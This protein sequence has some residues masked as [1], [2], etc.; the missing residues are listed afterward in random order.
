MP[1]CAVQRLDLALERV[2]LL[3]Q[4]RLIGAFHGCGCLTSQKLVLPVVQRWTA[5]AELVGYSLR[6]FFA[7]AKRHDSRLHQL[8]GIPSSTQT[9]ND[10]PSG[11]WKGLA[12]PSRQRSPAGVTQCPHGGCD[13]AVVSKVVRDGCLLLRV[14]I[15]GNPHGITH[16]QVEPLLVFTVPA[17]K[18]ILGRIPQLTNGRPDAVAKLDVQLDRSNPVFV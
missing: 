13:A 15:L 3:R 11:L 14:R 1:D 12:N 4:R 6:T 16:R 9:A 10:S 7:R 5:H 2:A 18:G 17:L 8:P